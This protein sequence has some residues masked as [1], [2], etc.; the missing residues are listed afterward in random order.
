MFSSLRSRLWLTYAFLIVTAL[1]VVA[2]IFF[3]YLLNNPLID[4]QTAQ[5][6]TAVESVLLANQSDWS[7]LPADQLRTYLK[8]QDKLFNVRLLLISPARQVIAD[9]RAGLSSS[10]EARR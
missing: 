8:K 9:S 5:R 2:V 6:L 3:I 4:R 7:D 1:L 10:L